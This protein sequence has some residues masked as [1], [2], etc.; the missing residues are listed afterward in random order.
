APIVRVLSGSTSLI[1]TVL[2][3]GTPR[4]SP[5]V[6]EEDVRYLVR[7]GAQKGIFEKVEEEMVHNVFDF[8]DT[9]VREIMTP[10][11][12]IKALDLHTPADVLLEKAVE[13]GHSR[14]P[15]YQDSVEAIIGLVTLRDLLGAMARGE[16]L[17]LSSLLRPVV[18]VPEA[19]RISDLL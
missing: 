18:F 2:G 13:A 10:R 9:A 4:D 14:I 5:F 3:M 1:L 19:V 12:H 16:T 8:A 7:E 6:S 11:P 15:V 17:Q